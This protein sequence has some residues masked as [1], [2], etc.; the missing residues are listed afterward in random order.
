MVNRQLYRKIS[1]PLSRTN[2][3][4]DSKYQLIHKFD[5]TNEAAIHSYPSS[6]NDLNYIVYNN[7]LSIEAKCL[8]FHT[9]HN[10]VDQNGILGR[11][12]ETG[13][14]NCTLNDNAEILRD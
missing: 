9:G 14:C 3:N 6:I 2:H 13:K 8:I 12:F 4:F 11:K 5:I 1:C 7:A 10:S